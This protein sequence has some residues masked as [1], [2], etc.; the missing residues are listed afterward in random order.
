[1][2]MRLDSVL[3]S[4]VTKFFGHCWLEPTIRYSRVKLRSIA[5]DSGNKVG[6]KEV[7]L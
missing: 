3:K 6:Q 5:C 1:M 7:N 2:S 4:T